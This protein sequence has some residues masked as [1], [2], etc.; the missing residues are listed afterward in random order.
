MNRRSNV[1]PEIKYKEALGRDRQT[2]KWRELNLIEK[3]RLINDGKAFS[4]NERWKNITTSH[5]CYNDQ[6]SINFLLDKIKQLIIMD[7]LTK[8]ESVDANQLKALGDTTI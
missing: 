5:F 8:Y 4:I 6:I 2:F 3:A 7:E 1:F